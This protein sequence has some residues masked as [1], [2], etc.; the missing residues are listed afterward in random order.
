MFVTA[1][2][3]TPISIPVP[4]YWRLPELLHPPV[5]SRFPDKKIALAHVHLAK[6]RTKPE[7]LAYALLR[8]PAY[9]S[10]MLSGETIFEEFQPKKSAMVATPYRYCKKQVSTFVL[11]P[12]LVV[13]VQSPA[14]NPPSP[15][16]IENPCI[17]LIGQYDPNGIF[18]VQQ[19]L[20]MPWTG[21]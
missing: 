5:I 12:N 13:I 2:A 18:I 21:L 16:P 9:L 19:T 11:D 15:S 14:G 3:L 4:D 20:F 6:Y 10:E 7:Y 1:P 17:K 8:N